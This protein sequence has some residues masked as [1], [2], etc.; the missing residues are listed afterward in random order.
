MPLDPPRVLLRKAQDD[1]RLALLVLDNPAV[2]DEQIGF[3]A[4][5]AVEKAIK[6][7]LSHNAVTYRRTHDLAE[8]IDL[9]K[10]GSIRYPSLLDESITLTPFAAEMRYDYL[11]PEQPGDLP[12]DRRAVMRIV[13]AALEWAAEV[14]V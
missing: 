10:T 8:L 4:Q 5:Q 13:R 2:S 14:V 1:E 6:A 7:V 12:L 9:L 3:Q 11:P